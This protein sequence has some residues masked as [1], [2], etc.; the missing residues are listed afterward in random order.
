MKDCVYWTDL[1]QSMEIGAETNKAGGASSIYTVNFENIDVIHGNHKPAMSIHNM[2]DVRVYD[3]H[4]KNVTVEDAQMGNNHGY[5]DGWPLIIDV[6]NVRGGEVPGTD[7]G[8][9]NQLGRGTIENVT[10]ENIT[11]L[12]WQNDKGMKPGVRIMNS[13]YGGTIKDVSIT[14][15]NY[16]GQYVTNANQLSNSST[17]I[18]CQF[19]YRSDVPHEGSYTSKFSCNGHHDAS[20][21]TIENFTVTAPAATRSAISTILTLLESALVRART[22]V[23][24]VVA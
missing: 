8:W 21:Y 7:A 5:G 18:Y 14:S 23:K 12:S 24:D 13:E 16:N 6:T 19:S 4:W 3:V 22:V 9:T 2:D 17:D 11:V 1:A 20:Y 10:F 15:L